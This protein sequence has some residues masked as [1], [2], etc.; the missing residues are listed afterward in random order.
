MTMREDVNKLHVGDRVRVQN[1]PTEV[2]ESENCNG[3]EGS[4][5]RFKGGYA[6]VQL[7]NPPSWGILSGPEA[8]LY[9]RLEELVK[10]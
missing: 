7:D 5:S 1:W 8:G 9:C 6:V 3:R 4:I 10:L 2:D